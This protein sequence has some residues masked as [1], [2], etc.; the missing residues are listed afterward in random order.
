MHFQ[1]WNN[2]KYGRIWPVDDD[3]YSWKFTEIINGCASEEDFEKSPIIASHFIGYCINNEPKGEGDIYT[4][5][6]TLYYNKRLEIFRK[7]HIDD[8]ELVRDQKKLEKWFWT[9]HIMEECKAFEASQLLFEFDSSRTNLYTKLFDGYMN[10]LK[11]KRPIYFVFREKKNPEVFFSLIFDFIAEM[12][13]EYT[14]VSLDK[15]LDLSLG[16][17]FAADIINGG[18]SPK[19]ED[20]EQVKAVYGDSVNPD[21]VYY[22]HFNTSNKKKMAQAVC[23]RFRKYLGE[24]RFVSETEK[25]LI[26]ER[27]IQWNHDI[28]EEAEQMP[29]SEIIKHQLELCLR[30][31]DDDN[32]EEHKPF[33]DLNYTPL[34]DDNAVAGLD[35]YGYAAVPNHRLNDDDFKNLMDAFNRWV[36]INNNVLV[37][38]LPQVET[39][40][41]QEEKKETKAPRRKKEKQIITRTINESKLEKCFTS[42]FKGAGNNINFFA[43]LVSGLKDLQTQT[44]CRAVATMIWESKEGFYNMFTTYSDWCRYF[45]DCIECKVPDDYNWAK[46]EKPNKRLKQLFSYFNMVE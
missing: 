13:Y 3:D 33:T 17:I 11:E 41:Q 4:P 16:R 39:I 21:E 38:E 26:L 7:N 46:K 37:E 12:G 27:A 1:T 10:Y 24:N 19:A 6:F 34:D 32:K 43:Q 45:F 36:K 44:E 42:K 30:R 2:G 15:V 9:I 40:E 8:I 25:G 5:F 22:I 20:V 29:N 23:Y 35:C 28:Q 14:E 31:I 18:Y